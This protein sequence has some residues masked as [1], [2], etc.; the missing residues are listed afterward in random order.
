MD[1]TIET[2]ADA[3]NKSYAKDTAYRG[4]WMPDRPAFGHCAVATLVA[5]EILGGRILRGSISGPVVGTHYWNLLPSGIEVDFTAA[6]YAG[7][8][9]AKREITEALRQSMLQNVDTKKR[10]MLFRRRVL[11]YGDVNFRT[12][13]QPWDLQLRELFESGAADADTLDAVADFLQSMA[14]ATP[15]NG[16]VELSLTDHS[17][18]YVHITWDNNGDIV[19]IDN[20]YRRD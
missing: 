20:G 3:F 10:Y 8:T 16:E 13:Y 4:I 6:Q 9:T 19:G 18:L 2:L 15:I 12:N 11:E 14:F 17:K 1:W 7:V 5:Q